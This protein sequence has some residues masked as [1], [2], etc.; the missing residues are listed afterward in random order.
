MS[1]YRVNGHSTG[2]N[3]KMFGASRILLF[4]AAILLV[5]VLSANQARA[6]TY[7]IASTSTAVANDGVCT[8]PEAVQAI[9][10]STGLVTRP[11]DCLAP[12]GS[13]VVVLGDGT[14]NLPQS[15]VIL[16]S[17]T[18]KAQRPGGVYIGRGVAALGSMFSVV[19][20][21]AF[22]GT[23]IA[24]KFQ[25][26][27][28]FGGGD[29]YS[30][31]SGAGNGTADTITVERCSLQNFTNSA[32]NVVDTN[33]VVIDS[34]L[35][36]NTGDG[37]GGGA[38]FIEGVLPCTGCALT[39]RNS[40][41]YNNS[42][43]KGGAIQGQTVGASKIINSTISNNHGEV[44][45]ALV[46]GNDLRIPRGHAAVGR[47]DIVAST[48]AFNNTPDV[49]GGIKSMQ[50]V[51]S[52]DGSLSG[53]YPL[54]TL[55]GSILSDNSNAG[56]AQDFSGPVTS[57]RSLIGT[58]NGATVTGSNNQLN[59]ASGLDPQISDLGGIRIYNPPVHALLPG[60]VAID[61]LAA[62]VAGASEDQRHYA[63]GFD[64]IT[65]GN[66]VDIGAYERNPNSEAENLRVVDTNLASSA[67]PVVSITGFSMGKGR[68][69]QG[70]GVGSFVGFDAPVA[71][72]HTASSASIHVRKT[73]NSGKFKI[74]MWDGLAEQ[75][76]TLA[77]AQDFYAPSN[78]ETTITFNRSF[79]EFTTYFRFTA[80]GSSGSGASKGYHLFLDYI[81]L[82]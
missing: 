81:R 60:S 5:G 27:D 78:Q 73:T 52:D 40:T 7:T 19:H 71:V 38:I 31:I 67:Y 56:V 53:L 61:V 68:D 17:M 33:L 13:D 62:P 16:T 42:A 79:T 65:G 72:G 29:T 77:A 1:K 18:V 43:A 28:F 23:S 8:L 76:V 82:P 44:A 69:I 51:Y 14:Y 2:R 34:T 30:G 25:D 35:S 3:G 37:D 9:N 24:V 55:D 11:A 64:A 66:T 15:V 39:L 49:V 59:V 32:L 10:S 48:I 20:D 70:T 54:I 80:V 74:E 47:L 75:W 4:Q 50:N 21:S 36:D 58:T 57:N 6:R 63:R 22:G 46:W 12:N 45:G 41:L 26:I